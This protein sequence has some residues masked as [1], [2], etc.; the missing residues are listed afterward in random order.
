MGDMIGEPWRSKICMV[1]GQHERSG[2]A[3]KALHLQVDLRCNTRLDKV[4]GL[5]KPY[6]SWT[7]RRTGCRWK[8]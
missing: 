8:I 3:F 5:R 1:M 7:E 2:M 4:V 6:R